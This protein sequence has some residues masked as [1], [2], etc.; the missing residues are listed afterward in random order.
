MY[1]SLALL[2]ERLSFLPG[3]S[4]EKQDGSSLHTA[5][6]PPNERGSEDNRLATGIS[7][8]VGAVLTLGLS[9]LI[10]FVLKRRH[11]AV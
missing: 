1:G 6:P 9:V 4:F 3:Y 10:G 2:Q 8:L 7:G 5:P 11:G